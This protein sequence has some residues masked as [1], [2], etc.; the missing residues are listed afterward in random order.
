MKSKSAIIA[1]EEAKSF[2]EQYIKTNNYSD[3]KK[4]L[5]LDNTNS[6]ILFEYLNYLKKKDEN[7][8]N[9]EVKGYKFYL[10]KE[11]CSKLNITYIDHKK[12]F[13]ELIKSI[14]NVDTNKTFDLQV[15]KKA[16]KQCYPEEDKEIMEAKNEKRINNL[17]LNNL[18]DDILFYL[19]LK[20]E[21]CKHLY[22]LV[23]F[24]T[25]KDSESGFLHTGISY[26]KIYTFIIQIYLQ[27][28]DRNSVYSLIQILNLKDYFYKEAEIFER[29]FYFLNQTG[30]D[31]NFVKNNSEIL[32]A[33]LRKNSYL[34][35]VGDD[36]FKELYFQIIEQILKSNCIQQLVSELKFHHKDTK[37]IISIDDYYIKY[38]KDNLLFFPF[39]SRNN[40]GLT[41]TLNG[42][43][44][45]NNV[46]KE[47]ETISADEIHLYNFCIWIITG[48]HEIVGHFLKD[49]YYYMTGFKIS[50]SSPIKLG[51]SS[52]GE[53]E[54]EEEEEEGG[55]LV[56]QILFKNIS[57]LYLSDV[58]Y[59][60]NVNNWNK[61]L[62]NFSAYFSS[63][64]RKEI[65]SKEKIGSINQFDLN[66]QTIKL[67]SF[68]NIN[69][70]DLMMCKTNV[71]VKCK[72]IKS[73]PY[74][75]LSKKQCVTHMN[76]LE[77]LRKKKNK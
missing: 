16:L 69:E 63:D 46:Y 11:S 8:F 23:N 36:S 34:K 56:E 6:L 59:I 67:L 48:I 3:L 4:A 33:E 37:G 21:F 17:P 1:K 28:N 74:I 12:D 7:L 50:E 30:I 22:L 47:V 68:F 61:S 10:D 64:N 19:S 40:Y 77:G 29:L 71:M 20:V 44:L 62:V 43:I 24:E 60:L 54:E 57:L 26:I 55:D 72:R 51:T 9:Q 53:D 49:Y 31:L 2:L 27:K 18:D 45:I 41:V 35:R 13:M 15:V 75:D 14:Q 66:E 65:I 52:N 58:I 70:K 73:Q 5:E 39:F 38:I 32:Y 25:E 42:K 76:R